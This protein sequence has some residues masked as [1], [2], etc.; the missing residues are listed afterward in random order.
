MLIIPNEEY[1]FRQLID[2][3]AHAMIEELS[4]K[5]E[6]KLAEKLMAYNFDVSFIKKDIVESCL[7]RYKVVL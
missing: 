5:G 4:E 6:K 1:L 2:V 7:Q 3:I